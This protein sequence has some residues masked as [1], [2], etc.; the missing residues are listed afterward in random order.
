MSFAA[1]RRA[2]SPFWQFEDASL[3]D[4]YARSAAHQRN[5]RLRDTL[6][7]Y[8]LRWLLICGCAAAALRV[9]DALSADIR[10]RLDIFVVMAAGSGVICAGAVCALLVIGYAYLH[11]WRGAESR[12]RP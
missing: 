2:L 5:L 10:G 11:L 7:R 3:G 12:R 4:L 9:F 8:L 6:P 1:L